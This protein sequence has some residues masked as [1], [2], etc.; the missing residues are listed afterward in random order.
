MAAAGVG[1][2]V[3]IVGLAV[4]KGGPVLAPLGVGL[5]VYIILGAL[6]DVA[7]R[8][9]PKAMPL[10][11]VY[12][13]AKGLPRSAWG[14]AIAHAGL[15]VTL[16]G[17][18][19][20]GWG[21]ER[22]VAV[23]PGQPVALGP[24]EVVI[25]SMSPHPGP[26]YTETVVA[27]EI[28]QGGRVVAAVAPSK[29]F[30]P[31]R[32]QN[33]AEAGIVTMG[34]GQV[35]ISLG[36]AHEDGTID[37]RMFWKPLVSLIW[38]G[39]LVMACGGVM[40]LSDRRLRIGVAFRSRQRP[41]RSARSPDG[42]RMSPGARPSSPRLSCSWSAWAPPVRWSPT[43]SCPDPS[44]ETRARDVS[45]GLRCLVC[46][47]Q[48]IDDSAAPLARDLRVIVRERLQAG[49]T[50]DQIRAFLVQRY[51]DFVLLKPPFEASTLLLWGTPFLVVVLGGAA[52]LLPQAGRGGPEAADGSRAGEARCS[53][54]K[55]PGR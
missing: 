49:D 35:Y 53:D 45:A 48:S 3:A 38:L 27:A 1:F 10:A 46:Q 13:R 6:T 44:L 16:L 31:T 18:A 9:R 8:I 47:N 52:L 19:A 32:Q 51:G 26:N 43:R 41:P 5:A 20:T 24:Y 12:D 14:T 15:G 7:L 29:R 55:T 33:V 11:A 2:A 36:D 42:C 21:A 40:S 30:F 22:I 34:L 28:R 50:D 23:K 4:R 54:A 37:T 17:L 39:A 25:T